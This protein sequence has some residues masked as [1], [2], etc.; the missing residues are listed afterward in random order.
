MRRIDRDPFPP[1]KRLTRLRRLV[2]LSSAAALL[3]MSLLGWFM[4]AH[5]QQDSSLALQTSTADETPTFD[6]IEI[7]GLIDE[8]V[9][10]FI[11]DS[12]ARA[13]ADGSGGVVLQVNSRGHVVSDERLT[14]VAQAIADSVV[15]VYAWVGPSGASAQGGA[16]QLVAATDELSVAVG[17]RFGNTG[18]L[19]FPEFLSDQFLQVADALENGTVDEDTVVEQG[20]A[21]RD[22][23]TLLFFMLDLPGFASTVDNSGEE[24]VRVPDSQV[25]FSKLPLIDGWVHGLASPAMAY[26]LF[27]IGAALL[28]FEFYTAGVGIAGAIG[29]GCFVVGC[30]GFDVLP[31]RNWA[32]ALLVVAM[33]GYA[34]DVQVGV[35][36]VWSWIATI[37]LIAGSLFLYDGMAISWITLLV[38]IIGI[39]LS[40]ISGMPSMIR[41]RFG[42]PT[43]GREWMVGM[44]AEATEDI[45]KE[46]I[47]SVDGAPWR[48]RVNRTTPISAGDQVRIVAIEGLYLEIEPETGGAR[49][50]REM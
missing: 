5:A 1:S 37:C 22:S 35:P 46:G 50:Y 44:M 43:I 11:E 33:F 26:L 9:A 24:P 48:A 10:D 39:A 34:I 30:Y 42:T 38:G 8:I 14:E 15:P 23:P 19:I 31:A 47:V 49:D 17:A 28:I 27:L 25:R 7:P 13:E 12:I 4:P 20:L 21:H 32:I 16:A 18:E 41:T 3:A 29:A 2:T 45:K 6:V 40:M 36:R